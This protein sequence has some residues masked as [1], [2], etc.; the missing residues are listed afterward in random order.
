MNST[1]SKHSQNPISI[2]TELRPGDIGYITYLHGILYA[3]EHG[4]DHTFE[5]YV[6]RPLAEFAK[7]NST[8]QR[9][10]IAEQNETIIGSIAIVEHSRDEAQLRWLLLHP[11]FRGLGLG[12]SFITSAI[13]FAQA[14]D[15]TS[16]FL[17][18]VQD[19]TAAAKLYRD[20]GFEKTAKETHTIW[21]KEL[22]EERYD[23]VLP[24]L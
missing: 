23:L 3:R 13:E 8:R 12:R 10:W 7:S 21:G 2:R 15:Y 4:W 17:W 14:Q 19:L 1:H 24:F 6:G 22:T 11:D 16:I 20:S 18:T 5:A 9:I